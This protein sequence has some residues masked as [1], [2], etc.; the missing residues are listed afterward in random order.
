M[1]KMVVVGA[2]CMCVCMCVGGG[3]QNSVPE[4]NEAGKK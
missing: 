3:L 2:V 4:G 1:K